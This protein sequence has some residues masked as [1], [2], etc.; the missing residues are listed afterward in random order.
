MAVKAVPEGAHSVTPYLIVGGARKA[1]EFYQHVFGAKEIMCMEDPST[2]RV[3]HAE[4]A[5]GDGAIMLADEHPEMGILSPKSLGGARPPI[6]V[7]L[8]LEDVDA[9][10]KRAVAAGAISQRE[11]QDQFYGDRSAQIADPFGHVWFLATHKEDVSSEEMAK[12]FE[13]MAKQQ[14]GN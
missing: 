9:V 7:H 13:Q 10:H 6:S 11:P 12:R 3:G 5:I 4:I 1:I 14:G 8:Y 2:G